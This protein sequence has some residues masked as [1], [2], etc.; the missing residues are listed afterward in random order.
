MKSLSRVW[1]LAT[2]RT[3]AYQAPPSMRFSRQEYWS[4][5]AIAF[6][7]LTVDNVLNVS[8]YSHNLKQME[9]C[10]SY[11]CFSADIFL[12][13]FLILTE[14]ILCVFLH[15]QQDLD[16]EKLFLL[17]LDTLSHSWTQSTPKSSKILS[18]MVW[19]TCQLHSEGRKRIW[20]EY[21]KLLSWSFQL[22]MRRQNNPERDCLPPSAL[23]SLIKSRK[24]LLECIWTQYIAPEK[25]AK[26]YII[27]RGRT[28]KEN[29][30]TQ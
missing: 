2:P 12:F 6:S 17:L 30:Y 14:A 8:N 25:S 22:L 13:E 23:Y 24:L 19:V 4:G 1:L 21:G 18:K 27:T 15:S 9:V 11:L 7:D 26:G 10:L 28:H 29:W 16:S 20:R 5:G 3:T